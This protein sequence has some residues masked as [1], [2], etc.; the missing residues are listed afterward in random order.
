MSTAVLISGQMR[1]FRQCLPTLNWHVFRKLKDPVFYVSCVDD[2]QAQDAELLLPLYPKV[3]IERVTQPEFSDAAKY[4]AAAQHAP[5]HISVPPEFI[6]RQSWHMNRVYEFAQENGAGD[7]DIYVRCRPDLWMQQAVIESFQDNGEFNSPWECRSPWGCHSPW[8]GRF[9]GL[10]DR[11]AIMGGMAAQAYFTHFKKI[12]ELLKDGCPFHP[13]SLLF[14]ALDKGGVVT[15]HTLNAIFSKL[16][17]PEPDPKNPGQFIQQMRPP[18]IL[19]HE[20][21]QYAKSK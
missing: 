1:T 15:H 17:L 18:E 4:M 8:W 14:A 3:F 11:F 13:E 6:L 16:F 20:I 9:G 19:P 2:A 5:Y 10:N 21:A 7:S 12:D